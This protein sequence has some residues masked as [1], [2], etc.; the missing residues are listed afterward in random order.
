[1]KSINEI[2]DIAKSF[3]VCSRC[4]GRS[5]ALV[6]HGMENQDRGN[7]LLFA[8]FSLD[9]D[10]SLVEEDQCS[11][12]SGIFSLMDGFVEEI[13]R[14]IEP[15]ECS[16]I[17]VGSSFSNRIVEREM[18]FQKMMGDKGEPIRK[19][20]SR[21]IGK[22]IFEETS[23]NFNRE[24]PDIMIKLNADYMSIDLQ[25]KSLLVYGIYR[26]LIRGIPQTKWIKFSEETRTVESI[27]GEPLGKLS[28]GTEYVLHGAG[29]EDVDVRMLGNGREFVLE[30]KNPK[31]RNLDLAFLKNEINS[32]NMGVEVDDLRYCDKNT[33]KKIKEEK[34][35]KIY[36][37]KLNIKGKDYL[38][39]VEANLD[40]LIGKVIYQRTPLRV[41]VSR[42]DLVRERKVLDMSVRLDPDESIILTIEAEAGTYIKELI[43]GD[44]GRT[45]PSLSGKMGEEIRIEELDVIKIKR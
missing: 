28:D 36:E 4:L 34:N 27:I 44:G 29:R 25:I 39:K 17:L 5:F 2:L 11:I 9:L 42:A 1:M 19:E 41:S 20:F 32:S 30:V 6:G 12:C 16:S 35:V 7:A 3:K 45:E 22:R 26:K 14:L 23:I 37:A 24:T 33:V 21:L 43:S 31:R 10:G 15:Y 13:K 40:E 38:Q 8:A 18:E